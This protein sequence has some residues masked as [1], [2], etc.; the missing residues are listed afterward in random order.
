MKFPYGFCEFATLIHE[1]YFSQDLA[2]CR[3]YPV[4]GGPSA[5]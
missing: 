5:R 1:G 3:T 2:A 4:S